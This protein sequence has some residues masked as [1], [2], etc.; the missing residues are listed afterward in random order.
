MLCII[1][2]KGQPGDI[3]PVYYNLFQASEQQFKESTDA[4]TDSIALNGFIAVR[5]HIIASP[6]TAVLLY[7]CN[8]RIGILQQSLGY[9]ASVAL[10]SFHRAL[11]LASQYGLSD[12]IQFRLM[13][14]AGNA[15][16]M[17]GLMDSAAWY[18]SVAEKII[19]RFPDA[20]YPGDLYNS[21]GAL[22]NELG[23][24]N[25]SGN[26]FRKALEITRSTRPQLQEAIFAMSAN[27]AAALRLSGQLDAATKAYLGLLDQ[28]SPQTPILINLARIALAKQQP[29]SAFYFLS[30]VQHNQVS[31]VYTYYNT[32]AQAYIKSN[33]RLTA[34]AYLDS[35]TNHFRQPGQS[36]KN[37]Y[38]GITCKYLGD[39]AL[40][41]NQFNTALTHYQQAIIQLNYTFEDS[42]VYSNPLQ[43][44]GEFASYDLFEALLAKANCF[45]AWY[46]Q[47]P[48]A[49]L[50]KGAL[51]TYNAAFNLADYIEKSIENDEAR[52][53]TADK[54]FA[55]Y[56]N[57]VDFLMANRNNL[58]PDSTAALA[59]KWISKSRAASLAISLKENT[60]KTFSGLPDSLLQQEQTIKINISRNKLMLQQTA[61]SATQHFLRS[62]ISDL[63]LR[64]NQLLK[65][66]RNYPVYYRE[67]FAA[68]AFSLDSFRNQLPG[69]NTAVTCYFRGKQALYAFVIRKNATTCIA[70]QADTMLYAAV[71]RFAASLKQVIPGNN[72]TTD[73]TAS[74]L[75]NVLVAPLEPY[76]HDVRSLL[77][78]PDHDLIN[79]PFEAFRMPGQ[80]YLVQQYAITYHYA[81]PFLHPEAP[82]QG[83]VIGV[84]FAPYIAQPRVNTGFAILS[85]SEEE[86]SNFPT[87][88]RI[89][90]S[91]ATRQRF[92]S[93]IDSE[94][95]LHLA[96]H[97]VVNYDDPA[98]SYIAF[99]PGN[100]A[101]TSYKLFAH[102]VYN[103]Q[104][105]HT[106]LVFLSACETGSGQL[107][108]S[109]G[110]LSLA[111]A[112]AYAGCPNMITSLWKAEDNATAYLSKKF[113]V[114][115]AQGYTYAAALQ[116]SKTDLLEDPAMSQFHAPQYWSH[117]VFTG[118]LQPEK[119]YNT[120]WLT[121]IVMG[122]IFLLAII[123]WLRSRK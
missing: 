41:G 14:A 8:E 106:R 93:M 37:S 80:Q 76:L 81:L 20:G 97:A 67:K 90:G 73:T 113:Y 86:I 45:A 78:I 60:I 35:A 29:D 36:N 103:L 52:R 89:T 71:K 27:I 74:Y 109:E 75:Y 104:M 19:T 13:L 83:N 44:T 5:D 57:A 43:F 55:G 62:T 107:L 116:Q 51:D 84:A 12:S 59:L 79:I 112:F 23:D 40:M 54:I 91:A 9:P 66:Y 108:Q 4:Y 118:M 102:E 34:A 87:A 85:A 65:T 21:L 16:Y 46:L 77:I 58:H 64:L 22:Y 88:Y 11:G 111:R 32:W 48:S 69:N 6:A 101:D 3:S 94:S 82:T 24:F 110:A 50:F 117:L 47:Q 63:E 114:Y 31:N 120:I 72:T 92:L 30:R 1:Q 42:N 28:Q 99:Y 115:I 121:V 98:A 33:D 123:L 100:D 95:I 61:D 2:P 49:A 96:T 119:D 122:I 7:N 70:L 17:E 26:Y 18:F 68:S 53:F 38:Y 105:P 39:V 56:I 10:Y 25:Q 15:H